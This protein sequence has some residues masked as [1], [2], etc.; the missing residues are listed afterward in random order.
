MISPFDQ[1][2]PA[3]AVD[4]VACRRLRRFAKSAGVLASMLVLVVGCQQESSEPISA[5]P[6][7]QQMIEAR[8]LSTIAPIESGSAAATLAARNDSWLSAE[9]AARITAISA[10]VGARVERG[11]V[12]VQLDQT[13]FKLALRQAQAQLGAVDARVTQ[14]KVRLDR[15]QTLSGR[16]FVSADDLVAAQTNAAAARADREAA[17]VQRDIA[18]RNLAKTTVRAPFSGSI[19]EREAQLGAAVMPGSRLIRLVELN[20]TELEARV[21]PGQAESLGQAASVSFEVG[22]RSLPAELRRIGAAVDSVSGTQ[23]ARLALADSAAIAPGD[24]GRIVWQTPGRY[25]L[26]PEFLVRRDAQVGAFVAVEGQARYR[27]IEGAVTGRPALVDWPATTLVI[28]VGQQSLEDGDRLPGS[29]EAQPAA[30]RVGAVGQEP[31]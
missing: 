6:V 15:A 23:V 22:G 24:S 19:S 27:A 5:D 26:P 20:R 4:K 31:G 8:A 14:T 9:V 16:G 2:C 7:S 28:V 25:A 11:D 10:D 13:D 17:A 1:S 29:A 21:D 3:Q 30:D 18:Q 12:L